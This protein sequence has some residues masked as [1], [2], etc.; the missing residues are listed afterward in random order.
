MSFLFYWLS[1]DIK[2]YLCVLNH[3]CI[4]IWINKCWLTSVLTGSN[5]AT[6]LVP[7]RSLA[8]QISCAA[9]RPEILILYKWFLSCWIL[10]FEF[11]L[12]KTTCFAKA[13]SRLRGSKVLNQVFELNLINLIPK[14][15]RLFLLISRVLFHMH[16]VLNESKVL[17]SICVWM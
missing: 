8:L 9:C 14:C 1:G 17:K 10:L 11:C 12:E 15:F 4:I 5:P 3:F 7:P 13:N 16:L 6:C 2:M